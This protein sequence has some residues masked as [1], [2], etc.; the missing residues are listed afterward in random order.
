MLAAVAPAA[1]AQQYPPADDSI[2]S[3]TGTVYAPG[4]EATF[5]AKVF[6]PGSSVTFTLTSDPVVLGSAI[7][8]AN[9]VATLRTR[10]PA[11][12]T[13][14]RHTVT[15]SGI[16]PEGRPQSIAMSITVTGAATDAARGLA[17]TGASGAT[18]LSRVAIAALAG[19]GL[20]VL[21]SKK[22]RTRMARGRVASDFNK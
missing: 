1:M 17:R 14:G 6:R 16:D 7:A 2:V 11:N 10:L 3:P 18:D 9:G 13:P 19:G 8:D 5:T 22:R 15:A 20:L 21:A 12:T 4:A